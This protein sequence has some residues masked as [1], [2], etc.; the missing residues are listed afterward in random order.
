MWFRA[1]RSR[2]FPLTIGQS[3]IADPGSMVAA[4]LL[5]AKLAGATQIHG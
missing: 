2:Y 4:V 1:N 3:G 5:A